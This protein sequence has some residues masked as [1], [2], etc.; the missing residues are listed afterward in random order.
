VL[1]KGPVLRR[2]SILSSVKQVLPAE[3]AI[4]E[5]KDYLKQFRGIQKNTI[6]RGRRDSQTIQVTATLNYRSRRQKCKSEL[7]YKLSNRGAHLVKS[8]GDEIHKQFKLQR[9]STTAREDKNAKVS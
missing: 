6:K 1:I 3:S 4:K 5:L 8:S 7:T 9:H 2:L